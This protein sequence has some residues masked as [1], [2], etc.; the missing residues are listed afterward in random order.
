LTEIARRHHKNLNARHGYLLAPRNRRSLRIRGIDRRGD[1]RAEK[2]DR[3]SVVAT[4]VI[5]VMHVIVQLRT[6]DQHGQQQRQRRAAARYETAEQISE[7]KETTY[8]H[9]AIQCSEYAKLVKGG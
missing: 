8:D 4:R 9:G 3:T 7:R 6:R 1:T 5:V 2:D